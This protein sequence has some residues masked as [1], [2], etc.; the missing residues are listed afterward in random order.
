MLGGTGAERE[1][2]N[3]GWDGWMTSPTLWTWVWVDSRSWWWTERP[4][5]LRFMGSQRVGH[6]WA[7]ELNWNLKTWILHNSHFDFKVCMVWVWESQIKA[8]EFILKA[9]ELLSLQYSLLKS[10]TNFHHSLP[11]IPHFWL[12]GS[13]FCFL[14]LSFI[15]AI[16]NFIWPSSSNKIWGYK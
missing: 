5:V 7:T 3:S 12:L 6:E 13:P 11:H 10:T 9:F 1:G 14:F 16:S 8:Y 15:Q 4:G 2:D